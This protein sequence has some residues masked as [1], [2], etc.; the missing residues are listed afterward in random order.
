MSLID[1]ITTMSADDKLLRQSDCYGLLLF[2]SSTYIIKWCYL[3]Y[4]QTEHLVYNS[5]Q[6]VPP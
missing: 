6:C 4:E 2:C 5:Y 1:V 3:N